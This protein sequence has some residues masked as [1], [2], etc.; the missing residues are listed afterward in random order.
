[1]P[2]HSRVPHTQAERPGRLGLLALV[3]T[4]IAGAA[5][6]LW[7]GS[8]GAPF[9]MGVDEPVIITNAL[10][11]IRTGDFNPYF[12]DYGGLTLYLH[13]ATAAVAFLLGAMAGQW[14]NLGAIWEG[15]L[16]TAG[17]T[18]TALLGT[19]TIV[20]VYRIGLRW[21]QGVALVA[22]LAMAVLP[23]HVREAHFIL[24]DT[25]LTFFVTL[26]LL[27]SIRAVEDGRMR[28]L[29]WAA[30]AV[31]LATAIKYNGVLAIL[32]PFLAAVAMGPAR[33]L[34]GFSVVSGAAALTFLLCAPYTVLA[35]PAFL[36]GMAA[37]MQ[38]YNQQRPL[39]E[40]MA[41]YIAYLRN[42]FTWPGVLPASVGYIALLTSAVGLPVALRTAPSRT[43][44]LLLVAFPLV[45]FWF[46]ST[47][48]LQYG[49]YLLPIG[50]MLC[51]SLAVGV[52][53]LTH[54][55]TRTRTAR[56]VV[57][58]AASLALLMPPALAAVN[59][60]RTHALTTTAEQAAQ[61]LVTNAAP[62]DRIVVEGGLFHLPPRFQATR[63][64]S[65][66]GNS[67]EEYQRDGVRYLV[68]TSAMSDRYYADPAAQSEALAAHRLLMARAEPVASFVPDRRHPGATITVLRVPAPVAED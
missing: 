59:W 42:W 15:D 28:T 56:A 47:Q 58:G 9:R 54:R 34:A 37:L 32:L 2:V 22:A 21:G 11:M 29:A 45:Y 46:I 60:N 44:G 62:G 68:A 67:I 14:S 30:A 55:L 7:G 51:V 57:T 53:A 5:L 6:R 48:A 49:R 40:V 4:L 16:L 3:A 17:R 26:A 36:N 18:A 39:S 10:R 64:N 43:V 35:L 23:A 27:L 38:S 65:I 13:A 52:S 50:P 19:A 25:P 61:W 12:F 66:I 33:W 41:N 63:T 20:L 24:T 1:M 31:G 8:A